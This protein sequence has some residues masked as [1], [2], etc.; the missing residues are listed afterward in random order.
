MKSAYL[1]D[2]T[3]VEDL[4]GGPEETAFEAAC[5]KL[6]AEKCAACYGR[7]ACEEICLGSLLEEC[8]VNLGYWH[9]HEED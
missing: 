3:R 1:P 8:V 2:D 4:P 5:D 6:R 9:E 7:K